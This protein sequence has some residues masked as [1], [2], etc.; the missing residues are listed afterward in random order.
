MRIGSMTNAFAAALLTAGLGLSAAQ[1]APL[2][3]GA[4]A[5]PAESP[6]TPVAMC[7]FR[8]MGGGRYIPG[9][10][11]VCAANGMMYCG[12]SRGGYVA[13]RVVVPFV[14]RHRPRC[15]VNQWGRTI[16]R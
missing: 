8:C 1:A 7:G 12:S 2:P 9:P 4:Q 15:F 14:P 11:G 13:P 5:L 3:V 10:P 6:V 16:C